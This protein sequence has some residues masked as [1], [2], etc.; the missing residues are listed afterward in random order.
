MRVELSGHTVTIKD[1][2]T[3]GD[4]QA[5]Q[6]VIMSGAKMGLGGMQGYDPTVL[7]E[8]KYKLLEIAVTRI[9]AKPAAEGKGA[10]VAEAATFTRNWM[11]DLSPEDGDALF[12][13][14]DALQ[15]KR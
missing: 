1:S 10:D 7:L 4:V 14:V 9:E 6:A 11:N 13:A 2:L 12:E 3:W 5:V 15:K 8:A